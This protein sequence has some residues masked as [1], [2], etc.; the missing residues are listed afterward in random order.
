MNR[1]HDAK[2]VETYAAH[3]A[4]ILDIPS[5]TSFADERLIEDSR[6][7]DYENYFREVHPPVKVDLGGPVSIPSLPRCLDMPIRLAGKEEFIVPNEWG[8]LKSVLEALA[9]V[10][11]KHNANW[12][13]Y[14]TYLTVDSS[15]IK[16]GQQQRHGGLHVDGFQGERINP[17]T[18]I[19]RNYVATTNGGTQFWPQPFVVA[20]PAVFNVFEGFDLQVDG[21]P[22]V[23]A[24]DHFYFM[25]A[26]TVHE[27]GFAQFDGVRNFIRLTFDLKE[28]DR[29]GN[30]HN[31]NLDYSWDMVER[32]VHDQVA[33]P[34]LTNII[35]SPYFPTIG[36]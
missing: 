26:Y 7:F 8:A 12:R 22:L 30:T 33:T 19:T 31:P 6:V 15:S 32:N 16:A 27:S 4:Y 36:G 25:D 5:T 20:D 13:D 21:E 3:G 9:S 1:N 17:K 28:F 23:A 24:P 18:K 10:E 2:I 35:A 29:A 34:R 11:L 14:F